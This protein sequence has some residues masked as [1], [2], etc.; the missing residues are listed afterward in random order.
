[1]M[2]QRAAAAAAVVNVV[3]FAS[4]CI[5]YNRAFRIQ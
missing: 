5:V 3:D 4:M 1:M 2:A